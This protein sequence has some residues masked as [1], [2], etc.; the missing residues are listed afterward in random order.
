ME[1]TLQVGVKILVKSREGK[2][3]LLRRSAEQYPEAA[4]QWDIVGGRI[5]KG[6]GLL[7]NLQRE[8]QEESGL[9]LD[10]APT[11]IAAQDIFANP[12]LHVVRLTYVGLV[13]PGEVILDGVEHESFQWFTRDELSTLGGLDQY[14]QELIDMNVLW[15]A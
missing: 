1:R 14:V 11:L 4:G 6:S 2:Y 10:G 7:E 9:Q 8:I 15:Q 12:Q 13:Q 3:L 5:E